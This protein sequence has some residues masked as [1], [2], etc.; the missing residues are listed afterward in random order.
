M[1]QFYHPLHFQITKK[2]IAEARFHFCR[3]VKDYFTFLASLGFMYLSVSN[4]ET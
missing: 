3:V 2:N 4:K 1:V